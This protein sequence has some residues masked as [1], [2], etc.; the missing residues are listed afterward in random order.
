MIRPE[1]WS[2]RDARLRESELVQ[3]DRLDAGAALIRDNVT[4]RVSFPQA[5]TMRVAPA[6]STNAASLPPVTAR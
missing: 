5:M 2:N 4:S 3:N 1:G 6:P